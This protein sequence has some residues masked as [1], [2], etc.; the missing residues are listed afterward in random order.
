MNKF[1]L[2]LFL[3]LW[4][5][6][7]FA[8]IDVY[9]FKDN[10]K[11]ERFQT[12]VAELRCPKCQNQNLADSNSEI[13]TDLRLKVYQMLEADK[14]DDM[15]VEYMLERYGEFVLYK[16]RMSGQT[17]LL[18][19]GPALLL[20]IGLIAIFFILRQRRAQKKFTKSPDKHN[21]DQSQ[22][23]TLDALLNSDDGKKQ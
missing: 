16:P 13:A 9:Q 20:I 12:L 4:S 5:F 11:Q 3:S 2:T 21:L 18:W 6:S 7:L 19:Y 15:I 17:F 1:F 14:S 22:Q 23:Q 8:A 10:Q